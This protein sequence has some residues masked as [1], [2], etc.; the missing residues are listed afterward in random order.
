MRSGDSS[1]IILFNMLSTPNTAPVGSP[2]ELLS[3]G[4]AWKARY[5]YDE[6]STKI[7]LRALMESA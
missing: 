5:K 7:S 6:P 3:G 2:F 4:S 1:L